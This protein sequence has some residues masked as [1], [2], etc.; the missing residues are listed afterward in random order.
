[1]K[2]QY[3][4]ERSIQLWK[5]NTVMEGQYSYGRVIGLSVMEGF[6]GCRNVI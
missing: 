3:R 5:V 6:N 1:M 2:G 4:Y